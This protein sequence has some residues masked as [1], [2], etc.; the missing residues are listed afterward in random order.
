M[1]VYG[2]EKEAKKVMAKMMATHALMP[3][4]WEPHWDQSIADA[5]GVEMRSSDLDVSQRVNDLMDLDVAV[6]TLGKLWIA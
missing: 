1:Q 4:E 5:E 3:A 2:K 6:G